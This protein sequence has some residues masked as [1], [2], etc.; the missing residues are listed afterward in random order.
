MEV[1]AAVVHIVPLDDDVDVGYYQQQ[2]QQSRKRSSSSLSIQ[3]SR[4]L[5]HPTR[6]LDTTSYDDTNVAT[7]TSSSLASSTLS[8]FDQALNDLKAARKLTCSATSGILKQEALSVNK[9]LT[10]YHQR[11]TQ[12]KKRR[13]S[14]LISSSS[15]ANENCVLRSSCTEDNIESALPNTTQSDLQDPTTYDECDVLST[16]DSEEQEQQYE[17]TC[18]ESD[19]TGSSNKMLSNSNGMLSDEQLQA[20]SI[21]TQAH[22]MKRMALL[23]RAIES[24]QR[25]LLK[26][27]NDCKEAAAMEEQQQS[28][29]GR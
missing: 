25:L 3:S 2:Q 27:L 11:A 22:R 4:S 21:W 17:L 14:E 13:I 8:F 5:E 23:L 29:W 16:S 15:S 19:E 18:E 10:A 6:R 1:N 20:T 9:R 26:E 12:N 7:T 28:L 24:N